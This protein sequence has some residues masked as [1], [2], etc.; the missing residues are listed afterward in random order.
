MAAFVAAANAADLDFFTGPITSNFLFYH[1]GITHS[2]IAAAVA[3]LLAAIIAWPAAALSP[4]RVG[5]LVGLAY[6]S[7]VLMDFVAF[8]PSEP[9]DM[10]ILW[11]V[12]ADIGLTTPIQV[13]ASI[14]HGGTLS[15]LPAV[16]TRA[17]T[18]WAVAREVVVMGCVWLIAAWL[19]GRGSRAA[20]SKIDAS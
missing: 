7:H 5:V 13:F 9:T 4:L 18:L 14:Q 15:S 16:V 12:A 20:G 10:P 2:L 1:H 6:A 3:G 11:P 17:A 19:A 8:T